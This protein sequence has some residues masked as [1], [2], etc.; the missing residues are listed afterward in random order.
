ML[1]YAERGEK[2]GVT[3]ERLVTTIVN[4]AALLDDG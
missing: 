1:V 3:M 4:R 2:G